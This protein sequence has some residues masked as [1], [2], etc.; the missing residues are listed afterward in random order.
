[1]ITSPMADT[2]TILIDLTEAEAGLE[3]EEI[4]S[5]SLDLADEL[6]SGELVNNARLARETDLPEGA[7]S[8]LLAF[9]GGVLMAEVNGEN[10]KKALDFLGVRFYGKTLTLEYEADGLKTTLE[11]KNEKDLEVALAAVQKLENIRIQVKE[12]S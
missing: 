6:Q 7:K 10:L 12:N 9:V 3:A 1:M 8:G 4:E 5:R 11:Y 2:L